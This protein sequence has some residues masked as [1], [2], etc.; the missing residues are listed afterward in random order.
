M[1]IRVFCEPATITGYQGSPVSDFALNVHFNIYYHDGSTA[2]VESGD[3]S[4]S[5]PIGGTAP[6]VLAEIYQDIK[7]RCTALSLP[8][9]AKYE[10]YG[11]MPLTMAQLIPDLPAMA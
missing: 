10:V 1:G 8:E 4:I 3:A 2:T 5:V 11:Y 9:P 6:E 7:D